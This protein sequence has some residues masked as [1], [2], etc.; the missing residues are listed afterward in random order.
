MEFLT[1]K[2]VTHHSHFSIDDVLIFENVVHLIGKHT[3]LVRM[4]LVLG[5]ELKETFYHIIEINNGATITDNNNPSQYI[6]KSED[7]EVGMIA[8]HNQDGDWYLQI[9]RD[10]YEANFGKSFNP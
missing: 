10:V 5:M 2:I 4:A 6:Y 3:A 7:G 9:S 1:A 8:K